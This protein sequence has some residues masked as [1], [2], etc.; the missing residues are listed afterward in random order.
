MP[1][2]TDRT[3]PW[4]PAA[5]AAVMFVLTVLVEVGAPASPDPVLRRVG[6]LIMFVALPFIALPFRQLLRQ[7]DVP[8]GGRYMDTTRVV[9]SGI[10]AIVRHPQYVGYCLMFAGLALRRQTLDAFAISAAGIALFGWQM[11]VEEQYLRV[12]FGDRYE[13]YVD[14]VPRWNFVVG[15][16]RTLRR[17][18]GTD[19]GEDD[20]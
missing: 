19:V 10:Y 7:G 13:D 5:L 12:E 20:R 1:N 8:P 16:W 2:E 15:L 3:R 11:V 6:G 17:R 4:M 9:D 14:R 18:A